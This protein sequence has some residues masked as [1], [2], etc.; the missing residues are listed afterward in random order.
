MKINVRKI[1]P[2]SEKN[3]SYF[4]QKRPKM[5]VL[6]LGTLFACITIKMHLFVCVYC[7]KMY[8]FSKR[9]MVKNGIK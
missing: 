5:L 8:I 2:Y 1:I 7:K 9:R 6:W 3:I 4:N